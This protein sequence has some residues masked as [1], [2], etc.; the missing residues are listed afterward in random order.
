MCSLSEEELREDEN[1]RL[2]IRELGEEIESLSDPLEALTKAEL[3]LELMANV[4]EKVIL[5][6]RHHLFNK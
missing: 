3:K 1:I 2:R 5:R 4:E 6:F